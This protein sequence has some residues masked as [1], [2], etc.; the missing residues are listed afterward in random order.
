MHLFNQ[1]SSLESDYY[2]DK[3]VHKRCFRLMYLT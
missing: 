1:K 2:D 3:Y